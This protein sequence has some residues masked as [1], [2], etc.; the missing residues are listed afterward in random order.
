MRTE[1]FRMLTKIFMIVY[2]GITTGSAE[3]EALDAPVPHIAREV[4]RQAKINDV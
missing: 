1:F 3:R 4:L 2:T